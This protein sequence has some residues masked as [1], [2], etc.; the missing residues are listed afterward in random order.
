MRKVVAALFLL[1]LMV[2]GVVDAAGEAG[3][4]LDPV[5][6]E[7]V[8][9]YLGSIAAI[10]TF[11]LFEG[12]NDALKA[13]ATDSSPLQVATGFPVDLTSADLFAEGFQEGSCSVHVAAVSSIDAEALRLR[14]DLSPL[15]PGEELWVIDPTAPR[16]FGPYGALDYVPG[17]RWLPTVFGDMAV[18]VARSRGE[19]RPEVG[20]DAVSHFYWN[21]ARRTSH[22]ELR[23]SKAVLTCHRNLA[24]EGEDIQ[25]LAEGVG[26]IIVPSGFYDQALCSGCLIE[27]AV[28]QPYLLT[29]CH[30]IPNAASAW[31]VE[32]VW[33]F[34]AATCGGDDA[35]S[36]SSL[37]RSAGVAVLESD[38]DLDG[39][40]VLLDEVSGSRTALPWDDRLTVVGEDVITLHHPA[41]AAAIST[42]HMRISKGHVLAVDTSPMIVP[43]E[44]ETKVLWD[45]GVTEAG[46]SGGCLLF[47]DGSGGHAVAGMLSGGPD[48]VC[49]GTNNYDYYAS[50]SRFYPQIE[51][52]LT[53]S[54][55]AAPTNVRASNGTQPGFVRVTWN[56]ATGATAYLV[57]RSEDDEIDGHMALLSDSVTGTSY[58]DHT[59]GTGG[60]S[61]LG[62]KAPRYYYWV[63]ARNSDGDSGFSRPD[64]GYAGSGSKLLLGTG[65]VASARPPADVRADLI[66]L[67]AAGVLLLGA[68]RRVRL[69][70]STGSRLTE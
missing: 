46:S 64:R 39:S 49:G 55:P 19:A 37:P 22:V 41:G 12:Q 47:D 43:F 7:Q 25:D 40:L 33:D 18:L 31:N 57:C 68:R 8:E 69:V 16:A 54:P 42:C 2:G 65:A 36:L 15:G 67:A 59:V 13:V 6:Q 29:A 10:H 63:R 5:S 51:G 32:V 23:T 20:L 21:F 56:A 45:E 26:F 61:C 38:S 60:V 28:D 11:D 14:V 58:D 50:F 4:P 35:P 30:C 34:K 1:G 9:V 62:N 44:H 24:C 3:A 70:R 27:N 48:H 53:G 66:V 52:Y 17:G